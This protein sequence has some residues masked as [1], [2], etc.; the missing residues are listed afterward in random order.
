MLVLGS[1]N[2]DT[3]ELHSPALE[4]CALAAEWYH[5]HRNA[6]VLLTGGFG[7]HFN[8]TE[9]PHCHY[10]KQELLSLGVPEHCFIETAHSLNTLEDA[11]LSLPIIQKH[12]FS[13]VW[14]FTSDYHLARTRFIFNRCFDGRGIQL[15]Y[16]GSTTN[17]TT[18]TLDLPAL[19][20]HEKQ[21]LKKLQVGLI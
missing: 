1:P 15:H 19:I 5:R 21:A 7:E 12:G 3:G 11:S 9:L 16:R 13:K 2:K 6:S 18:C 17:A 20:A 14:V 4:R 10:T 8:Q